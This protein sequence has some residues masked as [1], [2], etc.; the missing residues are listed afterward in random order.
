MAG[1]NLYLMDA[2]AYRVSV[3]EGVTQVESDG[4]EAGLFD[5]RYS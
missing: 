1:R 5:W 3:R 2:L 4:L